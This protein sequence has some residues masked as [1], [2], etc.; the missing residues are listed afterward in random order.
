MSQLE[1]L[2]SKIWFQH[3]LKQSHM[4]IYLKKYHLNVEFSL[5]SSRTEIKNEC[6]KILGQGSIVQKQ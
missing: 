5:N 4:G 3:V 6:D 2:G 1:V